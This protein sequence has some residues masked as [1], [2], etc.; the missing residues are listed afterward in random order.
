MNTRV[1]YLDVLDGAVLC[2]PT[3]KVVMCFNELKPV[4]AALVLFAR[5]PKCG[6]VNTIDTLRHVAIVKEDARPNCEGVPDVP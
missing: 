2:C 6:R 4:G 5:C 1:L 3:C